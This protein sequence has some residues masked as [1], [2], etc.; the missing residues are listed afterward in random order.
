[1]TPEQL[2][3]TMPDRRTATARR[4]ER[5]DLLFRYP[6]DVSPTSAV[7]AAS[8]TALRRP[9]QPRQPRR[10]RRSTRSSTSS[11]SATSR[12]CSGGPSRRP[13]PTRR[14]VRARARIVVH[15]VVARM[16]ATAQADR[17]ARTAASRCSAARARRRDRHEPPEHRLRHASTALL[18]ARADA[19]GFTAGPAFAWTHHNYTD[20]TFDQGAGTTA[21]DARDRPDPRRRTAPPTCAGACSR[22]AGPAGPRAMR[23]TRVMLTEGGVTSR[24]SARPRAG[25]SPTRRASAPSRPSS[26]SALEPDAVG[27]GRGRDRGH[28]ELPLVHGP[29]LRQRPLRNAACPAAAR[30]GRRTRPG[31]HCPRSDERDAPPPRSV[32]AILAFVALVAVAPLSG[33]SPA[34]AATAGASAASGSTVDYA[35]APG[36]VNALRASV[37]GTTVTLTDPRR[38]DH[39][40]AGVPDRRREH[41]PLRRDGALRRAR[42]RRRQRDRDRRAARAP[43]RRRGRRHAHGRLRAATRSRAGRAPT[44]WRRRRRRPALGRRPGARRRRRRRPPRGRPGG[45]RPHGRRRSRHRRLHGDPGGERHVR[46]PR[47]RR[48]ARRR[49]QRGR[50]GGRPRSRAIQAR[51]RRRCPLPAPAFAS[52]PVP[53]APL[54]APAPAPLPGARVAASPAACAPRRRITAATLRRRGLRV[55]VTC[56]PACRVRLDLTPAGRRRPVLVSRA[57]GAGPGTTTICSGRGEAPPAA[58]RRPR[59][60][61]HVRGRRRDR[62]PRRAALTGALRP[63]GR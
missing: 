52:A 24:A 9:L 29:E 14:P 10:A 26:S 41:G 3:A 44:R 46:R 30:R 37:S 27:G 49:R 19:R 12:T 28:R 31:A 13:S 48:R 22:A 5:Q 55:A 8:S 18:P 4:R 63:T 60:A 42:R 2:A 58:G 36:E 57:V 47:G 61:R 25:T 21:P 43:R 20:V 35:A 39:R 53:V 33:A 54:A 16:F 7:R 51:R 50:R 15:D 56:R 32:R 40:P 23:P 38:D 34:D 17:R 11:R 59:A 62:A 1:M 45:R 6:D